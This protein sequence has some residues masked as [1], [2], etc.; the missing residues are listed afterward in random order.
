MRCEYND[1]NSNLRILAYK[2]R[3]L[4]F[5][6]IAIGKIA[7]QYDLVRY[8]DI[9]VSL[10]VFLRLEINFNA[11]IT[12][13]FIHTGMT[14]WIWYITKGNGIGGRACIYGCASVDGESIDKI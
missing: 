10:P 3:E 7:F 1:T 9:N 11:V 14:L 4:S 6:V 2:E 8:L 12:I 5:S 13:A